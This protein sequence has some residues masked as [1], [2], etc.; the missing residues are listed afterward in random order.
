MS[1]SFNVDIQFTESF[2]KKTNPETWKKIISDSLNDVTDELLKEC[3]NECPVDT[4]TLQEGHEADKPDGFEKKITN[5][6]EYMPYVVYGTVYMD[7]NDYP[8]RAMESVSNR[9]VM[10]ESFK[11][12][13][14]E[15]GMD[16]R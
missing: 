16:A 9:N 3:K 11:R 15:Q 6:V 13:V 10:E 8:T 4:G 2:R 5:E 12:R 1:E 7:A 14:K